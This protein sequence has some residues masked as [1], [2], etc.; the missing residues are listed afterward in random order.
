MG[1]GSILS[2]LSPRE[3][4]RAD[5]A[6]GLNVWRDLV[7]FTALQAAEVWC[8]LECV[9]VL[10]VCAGSQLYEVSHVLKTDSGR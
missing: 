6:F 1:P 9:F 10:V 5:L 7:V 8:S 2:Q 3:A 4:S